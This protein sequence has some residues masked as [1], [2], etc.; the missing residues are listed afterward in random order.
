MVLRVD[1]IFSYWVITW[2]VVYS[3][4]LTQYSPK[5]VIIIAL[6]ENVYSGIMLRTA[7]IQTIMSLMVLILLKIIILF[8]LR[9]DKIRGIDILVS[10]ILFII[11]VLWVHINNETVVGYYNKIQRSL[12]KNDN[13][14]PLVHL[15]S[16]MFGKS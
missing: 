10:V 6:L 16:R 3:I 1:L 5:F 2:F 4:G 13:N 14:T 8:V 11:Y 7:N 15:L 12:N 9:N